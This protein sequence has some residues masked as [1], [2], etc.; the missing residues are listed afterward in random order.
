MIEASSPALGAFGLNGLLADPEL[1]LLGAVPSKVFTAGW[2]GSSMI[3][4]MAA[5]VGAF[6]RANPAS[7]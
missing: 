6:A 1:L 3:S 7:L 4:G 2:G 5:A